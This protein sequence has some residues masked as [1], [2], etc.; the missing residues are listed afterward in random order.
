MRGAPRARHK[1]SIFFLFFQF[2]NAEDEHEKE[3]ISVEEANSPFPVPKDG[4]TFEALI[5]N[6]DEVE[7]F[8]EFLNKKH[9]KGIMAVQSL[10]VG[11]CSR[12][13]DVAL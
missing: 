8:K 2:G 13:F 4:V 5:R 3:R 9:A 6:R 11:F 10:L 12:L 7:H 1:L